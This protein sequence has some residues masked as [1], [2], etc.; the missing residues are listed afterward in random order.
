MI[1]QE[2]A[3]VFPDLKE[4]LHYL[5]QFKMIFPKGKLSDTRFFLL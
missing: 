5:K 3:L 4:Y 2:N 1:F